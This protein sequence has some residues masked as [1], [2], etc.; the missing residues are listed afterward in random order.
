MSATKEMLR[1]SSSS[2]SKRDTNKEPKEEGV[3]YLQDILKKHP[4]K[5]LLENVIDHA[6]ELEANSDPDEMSIGEHYVAASQIARKLGDKA[7]AEAYMDRATKYISDELYK[8]AVKMGNA[9]RD[10]GAKEVTVGVT[11]LGILVQI[12]FEI[13]TLVVAPPPAQTKQG[14]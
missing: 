8:Q 13:N 14:K 3:S 12:T 4:T 1:V 10:K 7:K 9:L 11:M 2:N 6:E 5:K